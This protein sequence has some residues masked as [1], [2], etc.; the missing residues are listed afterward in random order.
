MK[1]Y[2]RRATVEG[3]QSNLSCAARE[4]FGPTTVYSLCKWNLEEH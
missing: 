2:S 3:S 1:G 4:R